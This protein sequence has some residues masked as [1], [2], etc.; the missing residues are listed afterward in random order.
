MCIYA[1]C[2]NLALAQAP[3]TPP[4]VDEISTC[5]EQASPSTSA[6]ADKVV[7]RIIIKSAPI[8]DENAP[9]TIALHRFANRF[10]VTTKPWVIEE[11]LTFVPG[12]TVNE[13]DLREAEAILR[14]ERYLRDARIRFIPGC[15]DGQGAIVSVETWD[16]WSLI[17][18]VSFSRRGGEN[19]STIGVQQ[20]NLLG[21]GIR[22][23]LRYNQDEQ[24]S[25]YQLTFNSAAPWTKH[26]NIGL[27]LI[28]N[29]DGKR[30]QFVFDQPFYH[31]G[32]QRM[33]FAQF[34]QEERVEDIFQN[35]QTR[36]SF[37]TEQHRYDVAYGWQ[38]FNDHTAS[39]RLSIG[40]SDHKSLFLIDETSPSTNTLFLPFDREFQYPWIAYEH[41]QRDIVVMQDIYLIQQPEDINLGWYF[42][43]QFG[44][45]LNDVS[46]EH[47]FGY[48]VFF[49]ARKGTKV[50]DGLFM[51]NL[52][53]RAVINA[54]QHDHLR[55]DMNGE[56]FYKISDRFSAYGRLSSTFSSNPFLDDPVVLDDDTGVR[57][58]PQQYQHGDHRISGSIEARM[59]TGYN[60]Y[61]LFDLGFA[62]FV[63]AG[64]A[65]DGDVEQ[66]NESDDVLSSVGIGARLFSNRSS[67]KGVIHIDFATP[68]AGGDNVDSWE[69]RFQM[70]NSF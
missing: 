28:D 26:A 47:D 32:T 56:Y 70:R 4:P 25:G 39:G 53:S 11:R 21:M 58:Y 8:F 52:S 45:E 5:D 12:S 64:K 6:Q 16:N 19:K 61:Q 29:D 42:R 46:S 20:D 41:I 63:D 67:N 68:L 60:F 59:Y 9:D 13:Q 15:E 66:F 27:N 2:P 38:L 48:Q 65:F 7:E 51:F 30:I 18:T 1:I 55:V 37:N 69:W 31:L 10:H 22:T 33:R 40:F 34:L 36:N 62:A 3:D 35:G 43:A 49:D 14:K 23:R 50:G 24:R 44:L 17:P 57:G 54:S